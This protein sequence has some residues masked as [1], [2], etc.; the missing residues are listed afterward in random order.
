MWK[1]K[2][3]VAAA[4]LISCGTYAAHCVAVQWYLWGS[5]AAVCFCFSA[6]ALFR[7]RRANG[8]DILLSISFS[9]LLVFSA[10]SY[11]AAIAQLTPPSH[12]KHFLDTPKPLR[13]VCEI[14]D[15]PRVKE[16]KTT[17]LVHVHSIAAGRDSLPTE[18]D[19][20]LTIVQD[21]RTNEKVQ[22]V[23]VR[24]VHCV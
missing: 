14:A 17:S 4:L 7:S 21:M 12:I 18:G 8:R 5:V 13:L 10:A 15:E 23:S 24:L 19:A 2:P 6:A 11:C 9:L 3:A 20:L 1:D 16:G 22:K